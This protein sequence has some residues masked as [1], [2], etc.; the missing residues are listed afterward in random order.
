MLAFFKSK[1]IIQ[2]FSLTF[3]VI[4]GLLT[5]SFLQPDDKNATILQMVIQLSEMQHFSP[6]KVDDEFSEKAFEMYLKRIDPYKWFLTKEKVEELAEYK[7][8]I[9]DQIRTSSYDLYR[10][11]SS[12]L[13]KGV[14]LAASFYKEILEKPFDFSEQDSIELDSEKLS[15]AAD[16]KELRQRWYKE[17]K[18]RTML[19]LIE[20]Q[21][22]EETKADSLP[23][24]PFEELESQARAKVLKSYDDMFKNLELRKP[25]ERFSLYANAL[26]SVFDPHTVYHT[27]ANK[28]SFDIRMSGQLEGIGATLQASDGYIKV[29]DIV[30][31]S[32]SWMQGELKVND[33]I[34][35]VKQEKENEPVDLYGMRIDDAVKLIRGK[36]GTR[37]TLTIRKADGTEH[38]I[39]ITRDVVI[40]EETFAKSAILK[41]DDK[42]QKIGYI[43]LPSF[44]SDFR[45][46]ADA[47]SC[48]NDVAKE[49]TKL[50]AD[51]VHGIILDLRNNTGGSLP[52]AI[53]MGGIFVGEN[54]PI[55]Q[56][57]SNSGAARVYNSSK[58][59]A[60]YDGPM[61]VL[62]NTI[63]ASASEIVSAAL[64]DYKRAVIVGGPSTFGKGTVQVVSN[65]D[66]YLPMKHRHLSPLGSL[67]LTI[68]KYYR[69]NGG[70]TQLQGVTPDIILPD[71]YSELEIGE[72]FEDHALAWSTIPQAKN[73]EPL[74]SNLKI[75]VLRKK[76]K[77]RTDKIE[78]FALMSKQIAVMKKQRAET[79]VSLSLEDYKND[80]AKRKKENEQFD[81]LGKNKSSLIISLTSTDRAEAANDTV[82]TSKTERWFNDLQKDLILEE[83]ANIIIDMK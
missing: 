14:A 63:S 21:K 9:D 75:D 2:I 57:K 5:C 79:S 23:K 47:R 65:L 59:K 82:K 50:K 81:N 17:M 51:G 64:Q 20:L 1:N 19:R 44:Y 67:F 33:L 37:V 27:P 15:W 60:S 24:T 54:K 12:I 8:K 68:N 32:P 7:Y 71:M 40:I 25:D 69:V 48:A 38:P 42:K 70:A 77:A 58:P 73:F 62:V 11:S 76:S 61:L 56:V 22:A 55:V 6:C 80:V 35:K 30:V 83:A 39:T 16:E 72:R 31:G 28:E 52:D 46:A 29:V 4:I 45:R 43:Y 34:V 13:D 26:L 66:E 78:D 36:K 3:F 49:V 53:N 10:L 74:K 18:Y 41:T